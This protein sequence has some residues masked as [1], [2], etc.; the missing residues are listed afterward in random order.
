MRGVE[1]SDGQIASVSYALK[2]LEPN[3]M[4]S[5]PQSRDCGWGDTKIT[6]ERLVSQVFEF[7]VML[8]QPSSVFGG[9]VRHEHLVHE[10]RTC[11]IAMHILPQYLEVAQPPC[12]L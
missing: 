6:G 12:R 2:G 8:E 4:S 7:D 3:L 11:N 5:C 9:V 10:C 1:F